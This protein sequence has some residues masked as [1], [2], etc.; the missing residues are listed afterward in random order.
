MNYL[1]HLYL[2]KKN[3]DSYYGNLLGDF[4]RGIDTRSLP[5]TVQNGLANH[6]LVDKFTDQH[7]LVK[8]SQ[9][10]F[11][12]KRRRFSGIALDVFYD[13]LLIKNWNE[14]SALPFETFKTQSYSLLEQRL[15]TMHQSMQQVVDKL[16]TGDWFS[17]YQTLDGTIRAIDNIANRVRFKHEF[18]G[19]GEELTQHYDELEQLFLLYFPELINHVANHG[20]ENQN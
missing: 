1:A 2:A 6:I 19:I 4:Q 9:T 14:F 11:S 20:L 16:I 18:K 7:T 8:Q 15:P 3:A 5:A 13:H 12:A 17:S 10:L